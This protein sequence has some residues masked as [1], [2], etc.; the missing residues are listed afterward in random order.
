MEMDD[1]V[2]RELT[3]EVGYESVLRFRAS[4]GLKVTRHLGNFF[5]KRTDLLALPSIDE[6]LFDPFCWR[7]G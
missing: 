6:V 4:D 2:D 1:D 7:C 5:A 3:R